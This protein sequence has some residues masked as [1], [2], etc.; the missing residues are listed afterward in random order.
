MLICMFANLFKHTTEVKR[1]HRFDSKSIYV[2]NGTNHFQKIRIKSAYEMFSTKMSFKYSATSRRLLSVCRTATATTKN[3]KN[4]L[5]DREEFKN[6]ENAL[7]FPRY[8]VERTAYY[9]T[10]ELKLCLSDWECSVQEKCP[11]LSLSF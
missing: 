11:T 9:G 5:I 10:F 8:S 6:T 4:S 2:T 7:K 3:N 1:S